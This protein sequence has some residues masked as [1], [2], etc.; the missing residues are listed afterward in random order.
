M[1]RWSWLLIAVLLASPALAAEKKK[2]DKKGK[3]TAPDVVAEAEA[4]IAAGDLAGAKESLEEAMA[5]DPRAAL[6]LGVLR[7]SQGELDLAIDA[8]KA[9]AEGLTGPLQGEA[10]G[11]MA[12]LQDTRGMAEAGATADAA[13]AA[14]PEGVWP[15]IAMTYRRVR[16]GQTDEAVALARKAVDAGG[17]ASAQAA[18]GRA[19]GAK[20]EMAAAEAAYREALAAE[21][22]ALMPLLGLARV[23]RKTGRAAEAEPLLRKA[24]DAGAIEAHKEMARV[25][26]ALGRP[27]EALGEANLAAVMAEDDKEAQGLV[28]EVKVA[29]A[30][31]E[32]EQ[33]QTDLAIEDLT[34]LIEQNPDSVAARLGLG[35]AEI[36]RRDA[37][38]ALPALQKA[39]ELDPGDADAQYQL[40]Y[41]QHVMK[42]NAAAAVGP[43]EQ[44]AAL[45]PQNL[46]YR[47]SLGAALID[48]GQL[49][50]AVEELSKVTGAEGYTGWQ[51][52][53]YLGTAQLKARRFKE[54]VAALQKA[55]AAN[56]DNAQAEAFLAWSYF[57]LKD[58]AGFKTH[59]AKA[60]KLGYK[61]PQLFERLTKVEAG[62]AIK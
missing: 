26:V 35:K 4:K 62:Q 30:L 11:R 20:G 39:V 2:D 44:A 16:E 56:P 59:G 1:N 38:A 8:Y 49:D 7:A 33:G 21:P 47:T 17:G 15:L 61:D 3:A 48:A 14:D 28:V 41:V 40:G 18:L 27:G 12:V 52:W 50:R 60:R 37:A 22:N 9:A 29:R 36:A 19:L 6:R 32:I 54:A 43:F 5:T 45:E 55:T 34:R 23:L 53:F 46:L 25:L 13:I 31:Q 58:A 57:G 24:L 10:L 51:A 42:Q